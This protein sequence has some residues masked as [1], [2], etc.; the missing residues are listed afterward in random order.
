MSHKRQPYKYD[1]LPHRLE[2]NLSGGGFKPNS[3][4]PAT[5]ISHPGN[6]PVIPFE[7]ISKSKD[8]SPKYDKKTNRPGPSP[9]PQP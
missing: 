3:S 6:M 7:A 8:P 9:S 1:S 2:M 5:P 4:N